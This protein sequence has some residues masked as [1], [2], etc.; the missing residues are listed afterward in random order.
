M[1]NSLK[2]N[3]KSIY[4]TN[5]NGVVQAPTESGKI[6]D[7]LR[8]GQPWTGGST[9]RQLFKGHAIKNTPVR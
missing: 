5:F 8:G 1:P 9:Y 4:Q 2:M 7:Q 3:L 6:P